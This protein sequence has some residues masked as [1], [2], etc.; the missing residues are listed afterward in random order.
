M[1][2]CVYNKSVY[3]SSVNT[4][5]REKKGKNI[6]HQFNTN[7]SLISHVNELLVFF[8]N[9]PKHRNDNSCLTLLNTT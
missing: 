1:Y 8:F 6:H 5:N 4:F 9:Q 7:K 3:Y 2:M